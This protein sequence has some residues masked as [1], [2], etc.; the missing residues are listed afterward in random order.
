MA[1]QPKR[2]CGRHGR[3]HGSVQ[4]GKITSKVCAT[5]PAAKYP[6]Y[7]MPCTLCRV[8]YALLLLLL[9]CGSYHHHRPLLP[10]CSLEVFYEH[11][12]THQHTHTHSYSHTLWCLFFGATFS[13]RSF[14]LEATATGQATTATRNRWTPKRW[15]NTRGTLRKNKQASKEIA[16]FPL[17]FESKLGC[18][19]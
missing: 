10:F 15:G 11:T 19:W 7:P 9:I 17:H 5:S 8:P 12:N 18:T 6:N 3:P 4:R 2:V 13:G 16:M 1:A 14:M